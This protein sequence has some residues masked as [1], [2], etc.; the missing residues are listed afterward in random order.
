MPCA[1]QQTIRTARH[2]IFRVL[3]YVLIGAG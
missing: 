3:I 2:P 1:G